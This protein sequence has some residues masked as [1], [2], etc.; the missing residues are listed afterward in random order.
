[1]A[2]VEA[3]GAADWSQA[4]VPRQIF[5]A[6]EFGVSL[7]LPKVPEIVSPVASSGM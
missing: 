1:M 6:E 3:S 4:P 5:A 2:Q 7:L